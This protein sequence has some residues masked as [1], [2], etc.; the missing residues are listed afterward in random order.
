MIMNDAW[1]MEATWSRNMGMIEI[2]ELQEIIEIIESIEVIEVIEIMDIMRDRNSGMKTRD[3]NIE[4][5]ERS[6]EG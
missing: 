1:Q 4:P 3:R 6:L 2:W 5:C